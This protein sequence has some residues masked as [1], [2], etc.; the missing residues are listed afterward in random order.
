MIYDLKAID[1]RPIVI[2]ANYRT[3]STAL[4]EAISYTLGYKNFAEAFHTVPETG[5]IQGIAEYSANHSNYVF[6]VMPN[7]YTKHSEQIDKM[8][9]KCYR[10]GLRREDTVAQA[11]SLY[12][13][14]ATEQ[15]HQTVN[16]PASTQSI[17]VDSLMMK[18]C[19]YETLMMNHN[20]STI[21]NIDLELT[22]EQLGTIKNPTYEVR[23]KPANHQEILE[24]ARDMIAHPEKLNAKLVR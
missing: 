7:Q 8:S 24:L 18:I 15:W 2:F 20:L 14:R 12:I 21:E 19:C 13:A 17:E 11:A 3:G 6:K 4:C 9:H 1:N 10:I 5:N 16:N 23:D 22:T